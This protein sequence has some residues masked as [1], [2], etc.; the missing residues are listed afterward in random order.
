MLIRCSALRFASLVI[1]FLPL[2]LIFACSNVSSRKDLLRV[3]TSGDYA[4]FS[5]LE[6]GHYAGYDVELAR[7]FADAHD[8]ELQFVPFVW[9]NL[10]SD[11]E[12]GRFDL[13]MSGVTIRKDRSLARAQPCQFR[14]PAQFGRTQVHCQSCRGP[15]SWHGQA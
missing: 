2:F 9:S 12:A 6:D 10:R 7:R 1:G 14:S 5:V 11:L 15:K 13:A 8:L 3:G 4:P